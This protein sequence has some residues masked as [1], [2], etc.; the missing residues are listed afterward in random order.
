MHVLANSSLIPKDYFNFCCL[1]S[2]MS[3]H[4]FFLLVA[5][6]VFQDLLWSDPQ[7]KLGW[8]ANPRGAGIKCE[9]Q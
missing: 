6:K 4:V 5:A 8:E 9:T 2:L 1:M 7:E 3:Y